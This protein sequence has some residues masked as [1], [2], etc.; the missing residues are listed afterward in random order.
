MEELKPVVVPAPKPLT[1]DEKN[2]I[3]IQEHLMKWNPFEVPEDNVT[4][5]PYKTLFVGRLSY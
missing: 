2:Q 5:D 1:K 3:R 4:Y